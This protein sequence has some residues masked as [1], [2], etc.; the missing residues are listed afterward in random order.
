MFEVHSK[1]LEVV[2]FFTNIK[3]IT[4]PLD[5]I[6]LRKYDATIFI[7]SCLELLVQEMLNLNGL[8][9]SLVFTRSHYHF[10]PNTE[11]IHKVVEFC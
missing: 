7:P 9:V 11:Y 1:E 5:V 10:A 8:N 4:F 6:Y 3:P 2:Y